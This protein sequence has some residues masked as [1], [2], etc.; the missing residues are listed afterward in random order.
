MKQWNHIHCCKKNW[1]NYNAMKIEPY[2]VKFQ[3]DNTRI[4]SHFCRILRTKNPIIQP[5]VHIS[6][7]VV[8]RPQRS[9]FACEKNNEMTSLEQWI[10]Q[11]VDRFMDP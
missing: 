11:S 9:Y 10:R 8:I 2:I 6:Y 7:E 4:I 3:Y 5:A 1:W